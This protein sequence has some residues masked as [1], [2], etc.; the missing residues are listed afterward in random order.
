M[1]NVL[2]ERFILKN[3]T[4]IFFCL[5]AQKKGEKSK[6]IEVTGFMLRSIAILA[7]HSKKRRAVAKLLNISEYQ[8]QKFRRKEG[9]FPW[10]ARLSI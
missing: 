10:I 4:V 9:Y 6:A 3:Q 8:N 7:A 2:E 5:R 1:Q